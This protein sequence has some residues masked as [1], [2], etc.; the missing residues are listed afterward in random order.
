L[1]I[2]GIGTDIVQIRRIQTAM[3]RHGDVFARRILHPNE[4]AL[5]LDKSQP[6]L[7][8]A[9]RFAAKEAVAKA[10]GTGIAQGV[11]FEDIETFNN[12][13]GKPEFCLHGKSREK[14]LALGVTDYHLSLSDEKDYA[15]A[16]VL[17]TG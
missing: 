10:L 14:A 4:F 3:E 15:V 6:E 13:A 5:F 7:Y 11:S 17:L 8:L 1:K 2:I 9:K 16:Y 12:K